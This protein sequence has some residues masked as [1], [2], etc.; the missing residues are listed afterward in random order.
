[1][2]IGNWASDGV[3]RGADEGKGASDGEEAAAD[4]RVIV[5]REM[6]Y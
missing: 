6:G 3:K 1:M 5:M 4:D 2:P